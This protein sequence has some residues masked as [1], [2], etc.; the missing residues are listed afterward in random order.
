MYSL[1]LCHVISILHASSHPFKLS[2]LHSFLL[3][4]F[5]PKSPPSSIASSLGIVAGYSKQYVAFLVLLARSSFWKGKIDWRNPSHL[6]SILER[7]AS[8][9]AYFQVWLCLRLV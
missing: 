1:T 3:I 6:D 8:Y 2:I 5:P 9:V 4:E 7:R